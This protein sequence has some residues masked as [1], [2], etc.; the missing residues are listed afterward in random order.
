M[1]LFIVVIVYL[2][3]V[4]QTIHW[5]GACRLYCLA[6]SYSSSFSFVS[7]ILMKRSFA[8]I[9]SLDTKPHSF[10]LIGQK[11]SSSNRLIEIAGKAKSYKIPCTSG[12]WKS[13]TC[14]LSVVLDQASFDNDSPAYKNGRK[15]SYCCF[16]QGWAQIPDTHLVGLLID[17]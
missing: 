6:T 11:H 15:W 16:Y 9:T 13:L 3:F 5:I 14:H 2:L 10:L 17:W 8:E 4:H 7:V 1:I 12:I